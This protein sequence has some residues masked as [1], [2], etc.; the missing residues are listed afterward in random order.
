MRALVVLALVPSLAFS[1]MARQAPAG[2]RLRVTAHDEAERAVAAVVVELKR[3]SAIVMKTTTDDK[4]IAEFANVAPGTATAYTSLALAS[5]TQG[6]TVTG[7]PAGA[8][9]P[10]WS[11]GI[12]PGTPAV[13]EVTGVSGALAA[14]PG[15]R[16]AG[17]IFTAILFP[18]STTGS[19]A[20]SFA[21]PGMVIQADRFF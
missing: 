20:A 12:F 2:A 10:V 6:H 7:T 13:A 21:N 5:S 3:G 16:I 11:V 1:V 15:T 17:S 8:T 18:A 14:L 4:G 19:K 9:T